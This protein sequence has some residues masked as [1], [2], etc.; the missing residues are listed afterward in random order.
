MTDFFL[1]K[2]FTLKYIDLQCHV[3]Y[4]CRAKSR[5]LLLMLVVGAGLKSG[6]PLQREKAVSSFL[7]WQLQRVLPRIKIRVLCLF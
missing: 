4:Y 3:N 7:G 1:K 5:D 2:I 6:C